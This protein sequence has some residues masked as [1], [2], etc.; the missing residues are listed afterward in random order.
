MIWAGE[1]SVM[2]IRFHIS[3][4]AIAST[5]LA[6]LAPF[7]MVFIMG[8]WELGRYIAVQNLLDNA[9]REGGRI[10]ASSSIFSSNNHN[11]VAPGTGTITLPPPSTNGNCEVQKRV[12]LYLQNSGVSTTGAT[13]TVANN[14]TTSNPKS[15][16][17]TYNQAGTITGSGYDPT[18][19]ANQLDQMTV[20]VTL[21]Y[22]NVSWSPLNWFIDSGSTLI[23]TTSWCSIQD[24]PLSVDTT[25]PSK[26]LQ[27]S[28]PL[29]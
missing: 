19:A 26:P 28:D 27:A 23:A 24:V 15:W 9:A 22:H 14:G 17:Y 11:V 29:P 2:R 8:L 13:V 6:L 5:E 1:D 12:L 7:L 25:I 4:R 10:A 21:P 18:A 16:S 3:R 20:T